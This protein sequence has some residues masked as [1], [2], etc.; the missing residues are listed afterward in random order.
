MKKLISLVA[1]AALAASVFAGCGGQK[2]VDESPTT[3]ANATTQEVKKD[4]VKLVWWGAIPP[5]SG[6]Q[7]V[8]D[9]FNKMDPKVQVEYYRYVN[10]DQG[11]TK[12]DMALAS[13]EQIDVFVNYGAQM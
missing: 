4:P 9:N 6:P 11:N 8:V 5:E 2:A 12:L 1:V 10:D 7:G 3:T 13:G